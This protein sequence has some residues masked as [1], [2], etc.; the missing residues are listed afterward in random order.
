M[1]NESSE[2]FS[3][4][5]K[6]CLAR[7]RGNAIRWDEVKALMQS[8][9][10]IGGDDV[11]F[12][13]VSS[14]D[15]NFY[16]RLNQ[17]GFR[18]DIKLGVVVAVGI[19]FTSRV[20]SRLRDK[21]SPHPGYPLLVFQENPQGGFLATDLLIGGRDVSGLVNAVQAV[22]PDLQVHSKVSVWG[23]SQATFDAGNVPEGESATLV[24]LLVRYK[25][26]ALEGVP[27]TGKSF[28]VRGIADN[29]LNVTGRHLSE[30]RVI[31][32][33][34][35]SAYEDL[36]EGLRPEASVGSRPGDFRDL[37]KESSP[38]SGFALHLG[39]FAEAARA[40]AE[41]VGS[42]HLLVLDE[43]NRAN[44]PKV[45]GEL[46][47][48]ME[49]SKRARC[50]GGFWRA[51]ADGKV[52]LTYSGSS[53]WLPDNLYILATMNTTDRSVASLD[54]ALRRRFIFV[55]LEPTP[56]SD[57]IERLSIH[58]DDAQ[59]RLV[60][61]I[62]VWDALNAD[63]L[64]PLIGPDAVL[65]HSYFYDLHRALDALAPEAEVGAVFREF[66]Q[67]TFLPQLIDVIVTNG[68]EGEVFDSEAGAHGSAGNA[69]LG[70]LE[71]LLET[72]GLVM[73]LE[74]DGL[75]RR[76]SVSRLDPSA[77][78]AETEDSLVHDVEGK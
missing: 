27:G 28:A 17:A 13:K 1:T 15:E 51:P 4:A 36:I 26:V 71:A 78:L 21:V 18:R 74:G 41:D 54:S 11:N 29:W 34:P 45:L 56:A 64:R 22:W 40:A 65:G 61:L 16:V 23:Q 73:T 25:N 67:Y 43:L 38:G 75:S 46:L 68:R 24:N 12:A 9:F 62:E 37:G 32:L 55:R 39:R 77:A 31:V 6:A 70:D 8:S 63:L 19:K 10:G 7:Q 50:V 76:V 52:R 49:P 30:P 20:R 58:G 72:Y 48:V 2:K 3:N 35:S 53:F 42:D 14:R 59:E 66:L 33:H 5:V 60:D 44:I 69:A 47:L 57:L